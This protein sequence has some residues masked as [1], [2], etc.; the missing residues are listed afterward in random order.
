MADEYDM[1]GA[2]LGAGIDDTGRPIVFAR[3]PMGELL[4]VLTF[5]NIDAA[6]VAL[7][8]WAAQL[9]PEDRGPLEDEEPF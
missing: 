9:D 1:T 2:T 4:F 3:D 7:R 6:K 8:R 5:R